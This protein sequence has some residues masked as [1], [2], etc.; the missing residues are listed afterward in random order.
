MAIREEAATFVLSASDETARAFNSVNNRIK[1][2]SSNTEAI[3]KVSKVGFALFAGGELLEGVR[4]LG[5]AMFD[6]NNAT[7]KIDAQR[8][9]GMH[10]AMEK[11]Q[12]S[13]AGVAATIGSKLA[14]ILES[15][16]NW[17][18]KL[19]GDG[20]GFKESFNAVFAGLV[21]AVG[22]FADAWRG[23]E[24]VWEGLKLAFHGFRLAVVTGLQAL[25]T[26]LVD[27]ANKIPGVQLKYSESLQEMA[28]GARDSVDQTKSNLYELMMKP[29][30][31]AMMQDAVAQFDKMTGAAVKMTKEQQK[32]RDE[33]AKTLAK[34]R[35]QQEKEQDD[36]LNSSFDKIQKENEQLAGDIER[37]RKAGLSKLQVLEE[38]HKA[39]QASIQSARLRGLT[40]KETARQ[41]ELDSQARFNEQKAAL[42]ADADSKEQAARVK[43]MGQFAWME[44][45]KTDLAAKSMKGRISAAQGLL[46]MAANLMQ[47]DR[48]KEFEF[49]KKAAIANATIEMFKGIGLAWGYGPILGPIYAALVVANG[50]AN[51]RQIKSQQFNGGG[52]AN[53]GATAVMPVDSTGT[54]TGGQSVQE[55]PMLP[56]SSSSGGPARQVFLT[57]Q[58]DSGMVSMEWV[59]NQLAPVMNEAAGDGVKF[60]VA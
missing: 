48:K 29:L 36:L 4:K 50:M 56:Q 40:D 53:V 55:A 9:Q 23:I 45:A 17:F 57:V 25:D 59:R 38:Q 41:L 1:E 20:E 43:E 33:A 60:V 7:N 22:V 15:V 8:L 35:E 18:V 37:M 34:A 46:G 44:K 3:A 32:A 16:A 54:P 24:V 49:G 31:S 11:A 13:F 26:A 39:E 51:I 52:A 21:R 10:N 30:P 14:P 5:R 19:I 2:V 12:A 42:Q 6:V 27:I 47:S 28:Q 58:S